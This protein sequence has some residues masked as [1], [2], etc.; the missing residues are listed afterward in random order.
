MR[1]K[2]AAYEVSLRS[3]LAPQ[4]EDEVKLEYPTTGIW[5]NLTKEERLRLSSEQ[6]ISRFQFIEL[7]MRLAG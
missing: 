6:N 7:L 1:L 2:M 4:L 5:H 3:T